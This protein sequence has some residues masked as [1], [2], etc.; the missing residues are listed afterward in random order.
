MAAAEKLV[1][2]GRFSDAERAYSTVLT[3]QPT[4]TAAIGN[5]ALVLSEMG[6]AAEAVAPLEQLVAV[7]PGNANL[8]L[9][10][11]RV[12]A[13][14]GRQAAALD[15]LK[16]AVDLARQTGAS[17]IEGAA[18]SG[19]S[20]A[21]MQLGR[22]AEAAASYD[23][24]LVASP[25]VLAAS[26]KPASPRIPHGNSAARAQL[27]SSSPTLAALEAFSTPED[28]DPDGVSVFD[29]Q[30]PVEACASIVALFENS[31]A[32]HYRGNTLEG[33]SLVVD[34]MKKK[35]TELEVSQSPNPEWAAVDRLLLQA[36]THA[37]GLYENRYPGL[38]YLPTPLGDEG[39][40]VKRYDPAF[41]EEPAGLHTWHVD[42]GG[43]VGACRELAM[44]L[45][46]NNITNGGGETL[47]RAP[48]KRSIAPAAGRILIFPASHTHVHAGPS[49][50]TP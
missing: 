36:L 2:Q 9:S 48:R 32:E 15:T 40:R 5:R 45:Y 35:T 19:L 39:F 11:G 29:G 47:F 25:G 28:V 12:L 44:L 20:A 22:T 6:R 27:P 26:F 3:H 30:L 17:T 13:S 14:L 10:L 33:N 34:V 46:L 43:G 4:Y 16:L 49:H 38:V 37:V 50:C 42:R 21:F 23:A 7:A 41:G 1:A 31:R 8:R 18:N 24:A